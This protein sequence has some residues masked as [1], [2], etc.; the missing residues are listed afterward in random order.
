[1]TTSATTMIYVW[2]FVSAMLYVC[3]IVCYAKIVQC[4]FMLLQWVTSLM[5]SAGL[6]VACHIC[7]YVYKCIKFLFW[8]KKYDCNAIT[9]VQLQLI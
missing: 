2:F 8:Q 6:L 7:A 1:M 3:N 9:T 4:T 5:S